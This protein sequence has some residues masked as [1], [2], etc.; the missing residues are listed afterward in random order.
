MGS[1]KQTPALQEKIP[2]AVNRKPVFEIVFNSNLLSYHAIERNTPMKTIETGGIAFIQ[3]L[4]DTR[5]EWYYGIEAWKGDLYEAEER[6]REGLPVAGRKLCLVHYPDGAVFFPVPQKEGQAC[7]EPVFWEDG[8]YV[9]NADF[10]SGLIQILRF[11]CSNHKTALHA[12][13]S[14]T[15][16]KDCYN[17]RLQTAPLTLARQCV[18][19]NAFEIVWP[20]KTRF[21][22]ESHDSFFL[23][24]GNRL[25]FNRWHE[26]GEGAAYRYWEETVIRDL[27]GNT[28]QTLPGDVMRMPNGALWHLK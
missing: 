21:P 13:L 27:E 9:L 24:D 16:V 12:E 23:R 28:I 2:N 26:E 8:I 25:F 22:M 14:L 11:D 3:A 18:G 5:G 1:E 4:P 10:P 15:S 19:S 20:E 7:G 17:L 6:F